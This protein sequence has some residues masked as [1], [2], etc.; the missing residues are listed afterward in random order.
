MAPRPLVYVHGAGP[1]KSAPALKHDLDLLLFGRD[2]PTTRFAHY[3]EVRWPPTGAGRTAAPEPSSRARRA[4]A[5]RASA[6]PNVGP[7]EAA[8]MIV[9]AT[10]APATPA[11]Q[12]PTTGSRPLTAGAPRR[13]STAR[14]LPPSS[15]EAA[16]AER[17][18]EQLLRRAD[19]IAVRSAGV[20]AARAFGPTFPDPIFRFVVGMFASDAVDYLYGPYAPAMRAPVRDAL[21]AQPP[22]KVIVAHSLGTIILYDVLSEP[23]L[24]GISVDL[25]VTTGSPLGIGNVQDRLRDKAG[26]PNPV[27]ASLKAWANFA[28]RW[29]PVT[30][31]PSLHDEFEPRDFARDAMVNNPAPN[32]HDWTGYLSV[33]MVQAEIL[34][35]VG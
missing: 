15:A 26:R 16:Q 34:A 17:F 31:D 29:D 1:Q 22:P 11:R 21:L 6:Q 27:P 25:L 8:A 33:P 3:A 18:V 7:K 4:R 28:D 20:P 32:N 24:S 35:A 14:P 12:P 5:V 2:M 9:A 19:R 13:P 10:L 30:L 23:S